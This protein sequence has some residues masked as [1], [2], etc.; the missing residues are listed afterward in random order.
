MRC[1]GVVLGGVEHE[2]EGED[3]HEHEED[4]GEDEQ[5]PWPARGSGLERSDPNTAQKKP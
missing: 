1:C 4:R 3:D 5:Y 2:E